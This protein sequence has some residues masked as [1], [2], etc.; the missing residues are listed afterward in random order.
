[1]SR[2]SPSLCLIGLA[3]AA[4]LMAATGCSTLGREVCDDAQLAFGQS[5]E[6]EDT[7]VVQRLLIAL[8]TRDFKGFTA[9][10]PSQSQYL[11]VAWRHGAARADAISAAVQQPGDSRRDFVALV[12]QFEKAGLEARRSGRCTRRM[13]INGQ[14]DHPL[15]AL[16]VD[17]GRFAMAVPVFQSADRTSLAGHPI[18]ESPLILDTLSRAVVLQV[19]LLETLERARLDPEALLLLKDFLADHAQDIDFLKARMAQTP[20]GD[21]EKSPI[22][23]IVAPFHA[24]YAQ[25]WLN[26]KLRFPQLFEHPTFLEFAGLFYPAADS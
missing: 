3:L 13:V 6:H 18:V 8:S 7:K 5:P 20:W 26:L 10:Q 21:V 22:S 23:E 11:A 15:Y 24:D 19:A 1:M 12:D 2:P 14:Q 4:T 16:S 17:F 9:M 25:R